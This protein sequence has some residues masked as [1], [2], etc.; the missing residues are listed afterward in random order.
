LPKRSF[1]KGLLRLNTELMATGLDLYFKTHWGSLLVASGDSLMRGECPF[2]RRSLY[3][4]SEFS[5]ISLRN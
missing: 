5:P 1:E 4:E 3:F 2:H